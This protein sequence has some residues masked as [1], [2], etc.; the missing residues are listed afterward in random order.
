MDDH[1]I[2]LEELTQRLETSL[3][4]GLTDQ[5]ANER[6]LKLGDNKLPDKPKKP[7]WIKLI[8][9]MTNWFSIMLWVGAALCFMA[10]GLSD[11]P[12]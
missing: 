1:R 6:N 7:W 9:E 8:K 3:E 2:S 10:Y 4:N 12:S 5:L 11:D